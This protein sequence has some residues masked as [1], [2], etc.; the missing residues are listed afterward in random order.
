MTKEQLLS[1]ANFLIFPT[2]LPSNGCLVTV[3]IS[4]LY[5]NETFDDVLLCL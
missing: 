1:N 2:N 5:L 4:I 3:D